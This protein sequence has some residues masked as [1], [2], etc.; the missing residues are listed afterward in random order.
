MH[1]IGEIEIMDTGD[2]TSPEALERIAQPFEQDE[3][4]PYQA[5]KDWGLG[6]AI[7]KSLVERHDRSMEIQSQLGNG[8]TVTVSLPIEIRTAA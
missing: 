3:A 5:D 8:T 6:F 4:D 2:G 7:T 1:G